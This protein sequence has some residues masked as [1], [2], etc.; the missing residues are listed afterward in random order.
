MSTRHPATPNDEIDAAL[1]DGR[2]PH[3]EETPSRSLAMH[4]ARYCDASDWETEQ[5][6][7]SAPRDTY[8]DPPTL[9]EAPETLDVDEAEVEERRALADRLEAEAT[10]VFGE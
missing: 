9:D 7:R 10:G 4:I 6:E 8:P 3:C 2:C 1:A 5:P